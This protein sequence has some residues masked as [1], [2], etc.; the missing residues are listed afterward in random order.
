MQRL[1]V[2]CVILVI[3]LH[4]A[5]CDEPD[6]PVWPDTFSYTFTES[7]WAPVIGNKTTSGTYY[8]SWPLKAYLV[9]R[10][11]GRYDRYCGTNGVKAFQDTPCN[12]LVVNGIRFLLYPEKKECCNCCTAAQGCG[13][14]K[15]NWLE[16]AQYLETETWN[17]HDVTRWNKPGLQDNFY[18]ERT[19]DRH[20][21][22]MAQMPN[23]IQNFDPD[24]FSATVDPSLFQLPSWA[25]DCANTKCSFFSVCRRLL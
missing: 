7:T 16:G 2:V 8:Y 9:T 24:S 6:S 18:L 1:L 14:L 3:C 5:W 23:D 4:T 21:V 20:M 15:K 10:E 19:S 22:Q 11:N 17:G 13:I 25:S 12:H